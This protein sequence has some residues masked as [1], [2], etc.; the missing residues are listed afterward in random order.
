M[1]QSDC[2]SKSFE[3]V[4]PTLSGPIG[5]NKSHFI[6]AYFN[7][8]LAV[9][10]SLA[11][12]GVSEYINERSKKKGEKKESESNQQQE[13]EEH[14]DVNT[15]VKESIEEKPTQQNELEKE[16]Q[17]QEEI[18]EEMNRIDIPHE[19]NDDNEKFVD[20]DQPIDYFFS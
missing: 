17:E 7:Q 10:V 3:R 9:D 8:E 6:K 12:Q 1:E 14:E 5:T 11:F 13:H 2:L 4:H 20:Q 15:E 19:Q 16:Q 18:N